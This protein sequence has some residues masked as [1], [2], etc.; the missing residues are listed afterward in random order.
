MGI[1]T[2]GSQHRV[3]RAGLR[4]R[5]AITVSGIVTIAL[6]VGFALAAPPVAEATTCR[7]NN[8]RTIVTFDSSTG[9]TVEDIM[10]DSCKVKTL[11]SKYGSV[12]D[13]AGLAGLITGCYSQ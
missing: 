2:L 10:I 5:G 7:G 4:S 11:V 9:A 6:A 13:G 8:S 12:K 3:L 1:S